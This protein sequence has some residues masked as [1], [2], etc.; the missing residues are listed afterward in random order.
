MI[1]TKY[2]SSSI[3]TSFASVF[4]VSTLFA[5]CCFS[6]LYLHPQQHHLSD[7][8]PHDLHD[9]KLS[10]INSPIRK[11]EIEDN[12]EDHLANSTSSPTSM[13]EDELI[14]N[15][16]TNAQERL[17]E[18]EDHGLIKELVNVNSTAPSPLMVEDNDEQHAL[19]EQEAINS[20]MK[21]NREKDE[22]ESIPSVVVED[23]YTP[24]MKNGSK[25][26]RIAWFKERVPRMKIFES[27]KKTEV[28]EQRI[29]EFFEGCEVRFF[30]VWISPSSLFGKRELLSLESVLKAHPKGCAV[31]VSK[32]MDSKLGR[33]LLKP[34]VK[35][36]H[37]VLSIAPDL[38]LLFDST[39]A[40][41][42]LEGLK[43]GEFDP[44]MIPIT[45]NLSNLLRIVLLYKYGGIY[46]DVD[47]IILK[48][49]SGLRNCVGIHSVYDGTRILK[50]LHN[51]VLIFDQKHPL[52]L[53]FIEEFTANFDGNV[54]GHNGPDLLTRIVVE[55]THTEGYDFNIISPTGFYPVARTR[56]PKYFRRPKNK[57]ETQWVYD[58]N[59]LLKRESYA[60]HLWNHV[61][62][63]LKIE[64]HS[65]VGRLFS[66]H[67]IICKDV[68]DTDTPS[69]SL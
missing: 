59:Y 40:G 50:S 3:P 41:P 6:F 68:Y 62:R 9:I 31:I 8:D 36:G 47:M 46:V 52:L 43:A 58:E 39:P 12:Y 19:I 64:Q 67:C 2:F 10:L 18:D 44:G 48:D 38:S 35:Q 60:I 14:V 17:E 29:Q 55:F 13:V 24:P 16:S 53:K 28:F 54:W 25:E 69:T 1:T 37:K 5:A 15:S 26:E 27:T 33:D 45:Q 34:I 51:A 7:D 66:D 65:L 20:T 49:V 61:S 42:W 21:S 56:L 4:L 23:L 32:S 22:F 30:M 57:N 63:K 11:A